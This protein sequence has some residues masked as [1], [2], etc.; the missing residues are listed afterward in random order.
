MTTIKYADNHVQPCAGGKSVY[1]IKCSLGN[2]E[3]YAGWKH[4]FAI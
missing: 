3:K 4:L 2:A 1:L